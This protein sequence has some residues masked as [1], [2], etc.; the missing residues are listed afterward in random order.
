MEPAEL[1]RLPANNIAMA[2]GVKLDHQ[3]TLF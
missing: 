1:M 3:Q 2:L